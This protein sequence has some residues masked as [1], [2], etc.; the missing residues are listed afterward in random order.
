MSNAWKRYARYFVAALYDGNGMCQAQECDGKDFFKQCRSHL[1]GSRAKA[2]FAF[3]GPICSESCKMK[4]KVNPKS[5]SYLRSSETPAVRLKMYWKWGR[6]TEKYSAVYRGL[7]QSNTHYVLQ[8]SKM[9]VVMTNC[10]TVS[11]DKV[12]VIKILGFGYCI[13]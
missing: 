2:A 1:S 9:T 3:E 8:I 6:S 5:S 7:Q 10:G 13:I 12:G 4:F 11:D